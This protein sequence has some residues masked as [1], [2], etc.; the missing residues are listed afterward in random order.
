MCII[1]K[2]LDMI[3]GWYTRQSKIFEKW[4]DA[5][6][7][8][9]NIIKTWQLIIDFSVSWKT[10]C[11]KC[12]QDAWDLY[13][14]ILSLLCIDL[15]VL[16]IPPFKIPDIYLDFSHFNLWIDIILPK[17]KIA[18]VPIW[19]FTLPDLP[20]PNISLD[21]PALPLL[22]QPPELPELPSLPPMPT[23]ELPN[24]PPPPKIPKLL[25]AIKVVLNI[26]KII[27]YIR[28]IIKWWIWLVA[29]R[30]VK[31]RIEQLTARHNRIFPFDFLSL[32]LPVL[33]FAW[34]DIRVDAYVKYHLE[35]SQVYDVVKWIA[36]SINEKTKPMI[37]DM[38]EFNYKTNQGTNNLNDSLQQYNWD[39]NI[40]P[41]WAF[42]MKKQK[43]DLYAYV[44]NKKPVSVNMAKALLY[45]QLSYLSSQRWADYL[46]SLPSS[47]FDRSD[48]LKKS[49]ITPNN[50]KANKQWLQAVRDQ[51]QK[52]FNKES[53]RL[54]DIETKM[55]QMQAWETVD[56][57]DKSIFE[58]STNN[59]LVSYEEKTDKKITLSTSLFTAS[60]HVY[61]VI[62]KSESPK[63]TYLKMYKKVLLKLDKKL[64][65]YA[66]WKVNQRF[67]Y[68]TLK[69]K[70]DDSLKVIDNTLN[71]KSV[72]S[73]APTQFPI[74]ADPSQ[75]IRGLYVKGSDWAYYNV[76]KN[77]DKAQIIRKKKTYILE[78]MNQDWVKDMIWYDNYNIYIKY[79]SDTPKDDWRIYTQ[80][81][82]YN[83]IVSDFNTI[84]DDNWYIKLWNSEFKIVD[85]NISVVDLRSAWQAYDSIK[86]KYS[87]PISKLNSYTLLYSSRVDVLDGLEKKY[88]DAKHFTYAWNNYKTYGV[89]FYDKKL[90][91]INEI[92][93]SKIIV[94][95]HQINNIIYIPVDMKQDMIAILDKKYLFL[96]DKWRYFRVYSSDLNLELNKLN[97]LSSYS[98]QDLWWEQ[99]I[100]DN[101]NPYVIT[102]LIRD[103][104]NELNH[105]VWTWN[106]L[107]WYVNTDYHLKWH[108][109]DNLWLSKKFIMDD[110]FNILITWDSISV[111]SHQPI[112][113][114]YYFVWQ[115][116][117][118]NISK[119]NITVDIRIPDIDINQINTEVWVVGS[120]VWKDMDN[121]AIKYAVINWKNIKIL[122]N[123]NKDSLFTWWVWKTQFTWS[124]F[125]MDKKLILYD[126]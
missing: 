66:K 71:E 96:H 115:D 125:N 14:C 100:A 114:T 19:V 27:W 40:Q 126:I 98:N 87:R 99:I 42:I 3:F 35:L 38:L 119:I 110:K 54:Q 88:N 37:W 74:S 10:T 34:F 52:I 49:V 81:Y 116:L 25:P 72:P 76:L 39:I 105:I 67:M 78:D 97:I 65:A 113:K 84:A 73:S 124:I 7:T 85:K 89:V 28:C 86:L 20:Y 112:K 12:R 63:K 56:T 11:G 123:L 26:L 24:L 91:K 15:P 61:N 57:S 36:D 17:I 2:Y 93:A 46:K 111:Y 106:H 53:L 31:T 22:P 94:K 16:P 9:I 55:K 30:N 83:W 101:T 60:K 5:I 23:L 121:T 80:K 18:P 50:V 75:N 108:W 45:D 21:L 122:E 102:T 92:Q 8:I 70:V 29:E 118:W 77:K 69:N 103:K 58:E 4:V 117:N 51:V 120:N 82:I 90:W 44:L 64:P 1:N 32:D 43:D 62:W 59:N 47:I 48:E 109:M 107:V 41:K 13:D 104:W 95:W 33:P 6:V 79:S 68:E